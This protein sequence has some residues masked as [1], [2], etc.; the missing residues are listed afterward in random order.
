[1]EMEQTHTRFAVEHLESFLW[2][3]HSLVDW[4]FKED[5]IRL[6][7]TTAEVMRIDSSKSFEFPIR[8]KGSKTLLAITLFMGENEIPEV[9]FLTHPE[10]ARAIGTQAILFFEEITR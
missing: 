2:E 6:V 4:G 3:V 8:F 10:L 9:T 7:Q 5:Q 1:M